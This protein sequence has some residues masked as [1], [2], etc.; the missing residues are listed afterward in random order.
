VAGEVFT[1]DIP[2]GKGREQAMRDATDEI[3]CRLAAELPEKYRGVYA[4]HPRLKE[5][6]A[7]KNPVL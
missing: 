7:N 3:M 2:K 1:V 4:E 5:L 6:L